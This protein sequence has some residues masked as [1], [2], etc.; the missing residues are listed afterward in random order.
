M[1]SVEEQFVKWKDEEVDPKGNI[2]NDQSLI[3]RLFRY[4]PTYSGPAIIGLDGEDMSSEKRAQLINVC[5]VIAAGKGCSYK[6]GDLCCLPDVYFQSEINDDYIRVR[7]MLK[8]RPAPE[9]TD[10]PPKYVLR[11][12]REMEKYVMLLDKFSDTVTKEDKLT[13]CVPEAIIRNRYEYTSESKG[14]G[15]KGHSK[16]AKVESVPAEAS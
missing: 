6:P 16:S 5:K 10:M 8:E 14:K 1:N 12:S 3:I 4:E 9:I 7:E 2:P 11:L 13:Y 15:T